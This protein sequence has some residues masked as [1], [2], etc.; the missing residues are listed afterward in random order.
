MAD[1]FDDL[2]DL[3][4]LDDLED[5]GDL[6]DLSFDDLSADSAPQP[7]TPAFAAPPPGGGAPVAP[8]PAAA[9]PGTAQPAVASG[10]GAVIQDLL[11]KRNFSQI[12]QIAESQ[13]E[14]IAQDPQA[15]AMVE[16]AQAKLESESYIQSFL[17]AATAA[18]DAGKPQEME[19]NLAKARALDPE[20]PALASFAAAAAAAPA[21]AAAAP[22]APAAPAAPPADEPLTFGGG[23]ETPPPVTDLPDLSSDFGALDQP[24]AATPPTA[25]AAAPVA[26]PVAGAPAAPV[27]D[28]DGGGRIGQLLEEG[29]QIY[30]Q[31]DFQAAIDIWSRIFLIDIDN[32]EASRL[33]E[34]ARNK[35]A[36]LERQVEEI[37]HEGT[38]QIE[39]GQLEEAKETFRRVLGMEPGHSLAKEYLEQLEAGEVPTITP[40]FSDEL[41]ELP[42]GVMDPSQPDRETGQSM[43]AAV[44]RDRVVIIKKT[45]R[46]LIAL[47]A[48]VGVLVIGGGAF[49]ALKWNE[50]F[51]NQPAATAAEA[52]TRPDPIDRATK[53][54]EAGS[55][56]N[57][58]LM[59][60]KIPQDDPSYEK[61][62]AL[63]TQWKAALA[64]SEPEAPVGPSPEQVARYEIFLD[65]A[66]KANQEGRYI[67]ARKYF[68]RAA[69]ILPLEAD[70]LGLRAAGETRLA[71]LQSEIEQFEK[72][73]Y[74]RVIPILWRK[75]DEEPDNKDIEHLIIDSYYNLALGDLQRGDTIEADKKLG[76]AL[77]IRPDSAELQR[78]KLFA[79]TYS[80]RAPDL[81]Y[82]TFVKYLPKRS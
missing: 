65:G 20:H 45:D 14:A 34:E 62:Q 71:S 9:Q 43:E 11:A 50:L 54:H 36:E 17:Q 56:E 82:R 31:G 74:A 52:P 42:D 16:T 25:A 35:K 47:G 77:E 66:R 49:V 67:R 60:E 12:I 53:M 75:R 73:E 72:G 22:V 21:P 10:L 81:I 58:I 69:K 29:K 32:S 37:F 57:A 30:A 27:G 24:A 63:V 26:D 18:R 23:P 3:G 19:A 13:K 4:S 2:G 46:K 41:D 8:P 61:A 68:E 28:A 38:A 5:L 48:L 6:G 70:D 59:L 33:I 1:D 64:E 51:P 76:E 79:E 15:R 39:Q 78:L 55:T 80:N 7:T 40:A 44:Q